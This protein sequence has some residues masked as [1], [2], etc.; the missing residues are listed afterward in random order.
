MTKNVVVLVTGGSGLIGRAIAD[1]VNRER[2]ESQHEKW[3]FAS[4][5]DANLSS[6]NETY[7]LFE[8]VRPTHVIHLAS[9]VASLYA[10]LEDNL[11]VF[12]HNVHVHENVSKCANE[13]EIQRMVSC[14]SACVFPENATF[15]LDETKLHNGPPPRSYFSYG[16]A[17]RIGLVF[18]QLYDEDFQRNFVT[19]ICCNVY[20]PGDNFDL[21]SAHVV[22]GLIHRCYLA[23]L[24]NTPFTVYGTGEPIRQF[25]FSIDAARLLIWA[26]FDYGQSSP[27]ILSVNEQEAVSVKKVAQIISELM[28]F[29]GSIVF[30]STKG[31][32]Q[33]KRPLS[34]QKLRSYLPDLKFTPLSEGIKATVSWFVKNYEVAR[35]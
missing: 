2:G 11:D 19:A 1:V 26:L 21:T 15:P 33:Q 13:F 18:N 28:E 24:N 17:E 12:L 3:I 35:K 27:I 34:N 22:S 6:Y 30:D 16:Y 20:G 10:S 5:K 8:K 25:L 23:K 14:C 32:G 31:D 9:K 29:K 7:E 4:S